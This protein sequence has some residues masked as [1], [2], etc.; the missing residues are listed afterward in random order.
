MATM[1]DTDNPWLTQT[2]TAKYLKVTNETVRRLA[3]DGKIRRSGTGKG[4]RFHRDDLD[5][6]LRTRT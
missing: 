1:T 4:Q 2:E 5:A 3:N 6:Y